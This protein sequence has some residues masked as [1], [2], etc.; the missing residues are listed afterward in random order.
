[1]F[2]T[3]INNE[4]LRMS[5]Q[6]SFEVLLRFP[7]RILKVMHQWFLA[8]LSPET[9]AMLHSYT[10]GRKSVTDVVDLSVVQVSSCK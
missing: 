2:E 1:M 8:D 5:C 3:L 7:F 6:S 4:Q 10:P 9:G